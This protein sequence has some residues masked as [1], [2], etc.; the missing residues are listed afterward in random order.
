M[1][2]CYVKITVSRLAVNGNFEVTWKNIVLFQLINRSPRQSAA[3]PAEAG[4][5]VLKIVQLAD[6]LE[7]EHHGNMIDDA[8]FSHFLQK[9]FACTGNRPAA[10]ESRGSAGISPL[11]AENRNKIT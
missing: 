5:T 8:K 11:M 6:C 1:A 4:V 10:A 7:D 9:Y 3:I 2:G